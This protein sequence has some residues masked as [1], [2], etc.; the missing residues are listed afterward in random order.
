MAGTSPAMTMGESSILYPHQIQP[1]WRRDGTAG[2]AVAG[3][4]CRGKV[5]G[6]PAPLADPNQRPHHRADLAVEERAGRGDDA[7]RIALAPHIELIQRFL[8]RLRLAFGVAEGG[9]VM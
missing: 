1:F 8:R 2:G 7:D 5:V 4:E 3:R 9:E 6:A